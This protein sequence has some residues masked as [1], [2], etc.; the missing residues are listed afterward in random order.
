MHVTPPSACP[1]LGLSLRK[2]EGW[3]DW[4]ERRD[5]GKGHDPEGGEGAEM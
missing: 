4:K 2:V 3:E 1:V 5:G